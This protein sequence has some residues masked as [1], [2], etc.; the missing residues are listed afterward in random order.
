MDALG[1]L[2]IFPANILAQIVNFLILFGALTALLWK[3]AM[4]RLAER[5]AAE[6]KLRQDQAAADTARVNTDRE[7]EKVLAEARQEAQQ[8]LA[9]A[10]KESRKIRDEILEQAHADAR[11]LLEDNRA[12][13]QREKE[14]I[15][16]RAREEIASLA[17]AATNRLLGEALD[18]K[19]QRQLVAGFFSGIADAR[20]PILEQVQPGETA[21]VTITSAV[22]LTPEEQAKIRDELARRLKQAEPDLEFR[23]DPALLGGLVLRLGN[24]VLD[25]SM[26][27]QLEQLRRTIS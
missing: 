12:D 9:E 21:H 11:K 26:A 16:L 7:K 20:V 3:P 4:R 17:I 6:E 5:Q 22:P 2:G 15:L 10:S 8:L 18:E 25:G 14:R 27:G 19:R 24:R 13:A 23:V 1:S